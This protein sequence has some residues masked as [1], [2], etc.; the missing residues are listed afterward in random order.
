VTGSLKPGVTIKGAAVLDAVRAM[1]K[2]HGDEGFARIVATLDP[3][4]RTI[5]EGAILPT[6]WYPLD[7]F[8][9]LLDAELRQGAGG[10]ERALVERA[11]RIVE[12]QLRGIYRL[13]VKLGS[14]EF[15]LKRIAIVHMTYYN[16]VNL[17]TTSLTPGRAVLRYTGYEPAHRLIGNVNIG[18]FKKALEMSGAKDV[19]AAFTV[20]IGDARGYAELVVTWR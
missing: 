19:V 14:P 3:E 4:A 17:E 12:K 5:F 7:A 16:G 6:S 8:V 9:R 15:V 1:R 18:F 13:F 11:E 10:D 2:G 20:P